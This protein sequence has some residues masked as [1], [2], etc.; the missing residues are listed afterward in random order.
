[1]SQYTGKTAAIALAAATAKTLLE[2][3]AGAADQ[4]KIKEWW[5]EFDGVTATA[6]PVLVEVLRFSATMTGTATPPD[7]VVKDMANG[8][9]HSTLKHNATS[10]GTA[11]VVLY[12]HNVPPTSGKHVLIPLGDEIV[13]PLSGMIGIRCTAPAIVNVIAG[14][15]WR[16]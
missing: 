15:G 5:V 14:F 8:A 10:E 9:A 1:M 7:P 6:V 16:E 3:T 2:L 13:V 12:R 4:V 11:G